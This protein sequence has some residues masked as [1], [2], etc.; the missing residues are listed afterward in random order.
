MC[1]DE[2]INPYEFYEITKE[3]LDCLAQERDITNLERYYG[4]PEY[5]DSSPFPLKS[6]SGKAQIFA[7]MAFHAQ[8]ATMISNIV[9]FNQE[10]DFLRDKLC[11]FDPG[12]FLK[13]YPPSNDPK[14]RQKSIDR[15]VEDLR[16]DEKTGKGLKWNSKKSKLENK[17]KI[18]KRY[19]DS[20]IYCAE[21]VDSFKNKQELLDDL[22]SH[23]PN[24]DCYKSLI[25]YFREKIK[26]GFSVALACDFLKEFDM[27]FHDLPK[28]DIHIKDTLSAFYGNDK[29]FY[30]GEKGLYKCIEKMQ[31]L[32][33]EINQ[34][35][36]GDQ[37]ITVYQLDR[38]IWLICSG[39]FFLDNKEDSKSD[40]LKKIS[41]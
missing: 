1:T 36:P 27:A 3:T 30:S 39:N 38:M 5:L 14:D 31:E 37:K 10:I 26:V 19:A 23:Y 33:E 9:K 24:K 21:Y 6:F 12:A 8:N 41:N 18:M 13:K 32:T 40:Y 11:A 15:I 16:Y 25:K 2:R 22:K 20:L 7:Q 17:D 35:L 29:R 28:P 34:K 4:L